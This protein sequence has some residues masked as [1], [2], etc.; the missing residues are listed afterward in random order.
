MQCC[1]RVSFGAWG[2]TASCMNVANGEVDGK[3][4]CHV[5]LPSRAAE[6]EAKKEL[7][8][9][10]RFAVRRAEMRGPMY[11]AQ[12]RELQAE[13]KSIVGPRCDDVRGVALLPSQ[14][15]K[16]WGIIDQIE[17]GLI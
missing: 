3:P 8:A 16:L 10:E 9:A 7:A 13:L 14:V 11:A 5:H 12:L 4:Y 1:A 17:K 15:E 2:R 6:R